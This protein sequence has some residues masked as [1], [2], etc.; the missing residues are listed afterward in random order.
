MK[1]LKIGRIF[2]ALFCFILAN[3]LANACSC[4]PLPAIYETFEDSSA[5]FVGK[6]LSFRDSEGANVVREEDGEEI[7]KFKDRIFR[8]EVLEN[9][10]GPK[11]KKVE[12]NVGPVNSSCY[13][14]FTVGESYLIYADGKGKILS[15]GFCSRS[16]N[17]RMA[18]DQI[19]FIREFLAGKKEPQ[20][21][22]SVNRMDTTPNTI[23]SR[24]TKLQSVKVLL[25]GK[26]TFETVTDKNG[27]FRF[28]AIPDGEYILKPLPDKN[29]VL[30]FPASIQAKIEKG[31]VSYDD[32]G[33]RFSDFRR[34]IFSEFN[35]GWNNSVDGK[36]F[37]ANG[38]IVKTVSV[39]L[40]P[41]SIPF[42]KIISDYILDT[43]DEGDY[44]CSNETPG[45]Y[46][47]TAEIFA[48][49]GENDRVRI[50]YPQTET[51]E[52][53]TP[54]DLKAT[55]NLNIDIILPAKFVT[56]EIKGQVVWSDGQPS[57]RA[58]VSLQKTEDFEEKKG[59]EIL[60]NGFDWGFTDNQGNFVLQAFEGGE[61]W[62]H[63]ENE[64]EMTINGEEKEITV[65]GKPIK[66]KVENTNEPLK[67][68][69]AKP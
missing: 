16:E 19:I 35:F 63:F 26:K 65:K 38:N 57:D 2:G 64:F 33:I 66:I 15:H 1:M 59:N 37:D 58:S 54:I 67:I 28:N 18:D 11:R 7:I 48:P 47:L 13:S 20:I 27:I 41:T 40:I 42:V 6:V 14:G 36:V 60:Y 31:K 32:G 53:A 24:I 9:F 50:F 10:K 61:Y 52:K 46:F 25:E 45:K 21:Y 34:S 8:F 55:D 39:R 49:F 62:L 3:Q 43:D 29:Y 30:F 23:D 12:V 56:R 44:D 69:L 51:P 22:G 68:I 4:Y 5:V 17:L